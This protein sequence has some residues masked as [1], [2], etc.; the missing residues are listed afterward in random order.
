MS[1][2]KNAQSNKLDTWADSDTDNDSDDMVEFSKKPSNLETK[3]QII[4]FSI[5]IGLGVLQVSAFKKQ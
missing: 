5:W 1:E 3:V 2:E 4:L